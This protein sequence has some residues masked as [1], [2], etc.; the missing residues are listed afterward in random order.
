MCFFFFDVCVLHVRWNAA[1]HLGIEFCNDEFVCITECGLL[2]MFANMYILL[3]IKVSW[4]MIF[5]KE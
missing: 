4:S 3:S 2:E 1:K 5:G